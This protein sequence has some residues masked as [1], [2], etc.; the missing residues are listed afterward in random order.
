[1]SPQ[2]WRANQH[3]ASIA[4]GALTR[5]QKFSIER[6]NEI[7][8]AGWTGPGAEHL[9]SLA[10]SNSVY[11]GALDGNRMGS[12]RSKGGSSKTSRPVCRCRRRARG[13]KRDLHSGRRGDEERWI[14]IGMDSLG[15]VPVVVYTWRGKR[16]R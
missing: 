7:G 1:M 11:N 14:S 9:L 13:C 5:E 16:V 2:T 8:D 3:T 10:E 4:E 12:G 6:I 15:C